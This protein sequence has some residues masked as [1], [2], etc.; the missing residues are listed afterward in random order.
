MPTTHARVR[1]YQAGNHEHVTVAARAKKG[2][3]STWSHAW[4]SNP[5]L[6]ERIVQW[7][8]WTRHEWQGSAYRVTRLAGTLARVKR[9]PLGT[10]QRVQWISAV[11]LPRSESDPGHGLCWTERPQYSS[12]QCKGPPHWSCNP[13]W[14][15][16]GAA[17]LRSKDVQHANVEVQIGDL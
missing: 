14:C 15:I 2:V 4:R 6:P 5:C 16:Y 12:R 17:Y 11:P 10:E 1:S 3:L 13:L 7:A 8:V 9:G